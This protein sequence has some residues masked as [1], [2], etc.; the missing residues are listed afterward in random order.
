MQFHGLTQE[1]VRR[2]DVTDVYFVRTLEVL[3]S[4]GLNPVVRAEFVAKSLPA[5]WEWAVLAGVEE[6]VSLLGELGVSARGFPEGSL[7]GPLEPVLE[8]EG[9]YRAFCVFETAL[10]GFLCQATGVATAAARCRLAA[11]DRLVLSFGARRLHPSAAAVVERA[12]YLGGCD[13]VATV[14]GARLIGMEPSGTMPHALVLVLGDTVEATRA[15]HEA[16]D[17]S[18]PRVSLIDTFHDEKF[19]AVRVAEEL[20]EALASVRLDT[21]GTRRGDFYRILEE[22]RWELDSRGHGKVGLFVSG[23]IDEEKILGLNPLAA[24]YGVGGAIAAAPIVDFS[25]DIVELEGK[26]LAKR[27]KWSGAKQVLECRECGGRRIVP[28]REKGAACPL[29][30][31]RTAGLMQPLVREGRVVAEPPSAGAIRERVLEAL[32]NHERSGKDE[33]G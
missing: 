32:G 16:V 8:I 24:G 4:R 9:P 5:D 18:V 15:F 1:D 25:M 21:P 3:E 10:L 28:L 26:P 20:G 22:V 23:G 7:F 29:C 13:G 12:A 27:G 11:G 14:A 19:E 17:P 30:G 2:G 33:S 6:T 31:G